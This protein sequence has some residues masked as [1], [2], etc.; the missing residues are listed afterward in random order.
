MSTYRTLVADPPWP[1]TWTG[2]S[3]KAGKSS[4]STLVHGKKP[5]PYTTMALE[6]MRDLGELVRWKAEDDAHLFMWTLDR[7]VLNGWAPAVARAW[8]FEPL[9]HMIVWR[10]ANPGLGRIVRPAHELLLIARRGNARLAEVAI[11]SVQDWKQPY[12]NG[13]K[14]HS[15][16]PD[17]ALDLIEALSPGPYLE[18]FARRARF[19][20]DYYGDESLGTAELSRDGAAA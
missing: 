6:Q 16:K 11:P 18:L 14:A 1:I 7:F 12:E 4:G 10:K 15:A 19:G 20:W 9:P 13:A 8:G 5:L 3:R 17:G 2:G